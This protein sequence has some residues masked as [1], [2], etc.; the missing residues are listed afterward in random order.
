[1]ESIVARNQVMAIMPPKIIKVE[2]SQRTSKFE[3]IVEESISLDEECAAGII[4]FGEVA[5]APVITVQKQAFRS[6]LDTIWEG[7]MQYVAEYFVS[8]VADAMRRSSP[9]L[10]PNYSNFDIQERVH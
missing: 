10:R 5:P 4:T 2:K 3:T 1:M 6:S 9:V 7:R 8:E